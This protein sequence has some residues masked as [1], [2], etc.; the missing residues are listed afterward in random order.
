FL[1]DGYF[2]GPD[3]VDCV[4]L[5]S[6]DP[7]RAIEEKQ[8]PAESAVREIVVL[9]LQKKRLYLIVFLKNQLGVKLLLHS[10]GGIRKRHERGEYLG[11]ELHQRKCDGFVGFWRI[12]RADIRRCATR[13]QHTSGGQN[14]YRQ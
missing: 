1:I 8:D 13:T 12:R 3:V 11:V 4:R 14:Q 7:F 9:R 5:Q 6:D 10:L 2:E